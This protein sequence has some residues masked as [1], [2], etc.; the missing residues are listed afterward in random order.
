MHRVVISFLVRRYI[1]VTSL[2]PSRSAIRTRIGSC[3]PAA[4]DDDTL[5]QI[6]AL[7]QLTRARFTADSAPGALYPGMPAALPTMAP[8]KE[9]WRHH[10]LLEIVDLIIAAHPL[11]CTELHAK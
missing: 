10:H 11:V 3:E 8:M 5:A 9:K 7:T 2:A 6:N 4:N 1:M